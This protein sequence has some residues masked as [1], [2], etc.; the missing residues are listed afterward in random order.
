MA[1]FRAYVPVDFLYGELPS[2]TV[3]KATSTEVVLF[4][5]YTTTTFRGTGFTY[6]GNYIT[7]GTLTSFSAVQNGGVIM[8]ASD[9]NLFAPV[10]AEDIL[11]GDL[12]GLLVYALAGNDRIYGSPFS[13]RIA[14]ATGDDYLD[15]GTGDDIVYGADGIDTVFLEGTL[16]DYMLTPYTDGSVVVTDLNFSNG[17]EGIDTLYG[18]EILAFA[19]GEQ[20]FLNSLINPVIWYKQI[21]SVELVASTY[22]FFTDRV[23]TA[24][25]FGYLISSL[26]NPADLND[27]YYAQFNIENRYINFASN[28]GTEGEGKAFYNAAF[29]SLTFEQAIMLAYQE[30]MGKP[31][32]GGAYNFFMGAHGFY[33]DVAEQRVVR[34]GVDLDDATKIVAIGSILNEAVKGGGGRYAEAIDDLVNDVY[35][36][37]Y[38]AMLGGDLFAIA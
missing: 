31:L 33:E 14:G 26:S 30:I 10:I 11:T 21:E 34:P 9:L 8:E 24:N 12:V 2:G 3:M 25:G 7:G 22:Q 37:G 32:T 36:D 28:L 20:Y 17:N 38:S 19:S 6:A 16:G 29:G 18:V 23:P 35:P 5:G 13:D 27:P 15:P 4:N 1:V